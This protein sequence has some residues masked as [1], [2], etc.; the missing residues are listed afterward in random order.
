[1]AGRPPEPGIRD[2]EDEG[3]V[4]RGERVDGDREIRSTRSRRDPPGPSGVSIASS[5]STITFTSARPP[6]RALYCGRDMLDPQPVPR[7]DADRLPDAA[8]GDVGAPVPAHVA[9]HLPQ[10]VVRVR[11]IATV[12]G[13]GQASGALPKR[14]GGRRGGGEGDRERVRAG[15]GGGSQVEPVGPVHVLSRAD[16]DGVQRQR[17]QRVQARRRPGRVGRRGRAGRPAG[18]TWP[19]TA[20]RR[21]RSR[22]GGARC[23]PG[24][25]RRAGRRPSGRCGRSR[26]P[27]PGTPAASRPR[28]SATIG[29]RSPTAWRVHDAVWSERRVMPARRCSTWYSPPEI[30]VGTIVPHG[31]PG[32]CGSACS[33]SLR[34]WRWRCWRAAH[35]P[36]NGCPRTGSW[37]STGETWTG[38]EGGGHAVGGWTTSTPPSGGTKGSTSAT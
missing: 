15:P 20:S 24:T 7:L 8:G 18:R 30:L 9:G 22:T 4:V 27:S 12:A 10:H 31:G 5:V 13:V 35:G 17:G 16:R 2:V 19:C 6:T 37:S 36:A 3:S 14:L 11:H 32:W 34:G 26:A 25:G 29:A 21:G 38:T 33:S 23:R 1:M 28:N